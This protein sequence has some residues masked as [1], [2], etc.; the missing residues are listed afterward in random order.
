MRSFYWIV[1]AGHTDRCKK[2]CG[3]GHCDLRV[4]SV[5][6]DGSRRQDT[7]DSEVS[8]SQFGRIQEG[9]AMD[10]EVVFKYLD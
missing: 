3:N 1:F 9:M 6:N 10:E 7:R 4:A 5:A 2:C 8:V